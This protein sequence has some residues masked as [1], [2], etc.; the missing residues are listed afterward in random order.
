M[1]LRAFTACLWLA[2]LLAAAPR[3]ASAQET[4]NGPLAVSHPVLAASLE[5]L[6]EGSA[7]W[8]EAL[9]ALT[10]TGRRTIITTPD[11]AE[12]GFDLD[13]LAQALPILDDQQRVQEVVV[14]INLELMQRMSGLPVKAVQFEDDLDRIIA[15]EVF[16][17]A[18]PLLL[19]G[20]MAG[21]CA[22]PAPGQRATDACAI[23]RE[24]QIRKELKLGRRF[25]YGREGLALARRSQQE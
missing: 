18:I 2:T 23:K 20:D 21:H 16:G 6:S 25:D 24:N 12:R 5:R 19:A 8:R 3:D 15:H 22:D 4:S 1:A 11:K 17:H 9:D 10:G 14:A 7:S 13:Q